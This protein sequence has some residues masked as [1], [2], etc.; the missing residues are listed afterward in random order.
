MKKVIVLFLLLESSLLSAQTIEGLYIETERLHLYPSSN[1]ILDIPS[2]DITGH[3]NL[4]IALS[5]IY[6]NS[7]F[8][9]TYE[10]NEYNIVKHSISPSL[11]FTIG[12]LE[13]VEIGV[14]IGPQIIKQ[15]TNIDTETKRLNITP[16][17]DLI[18]YLKL[19]SFELIKNFYLTT[20]VQFTIPIAKLIGKEFSGFTS[21]SVYP[22][23][24]STYKFK[25]IWLSLSLGYRLLPE[26]VIYK[27]DSY[28][29]G[30]STS[31]F[32][33]TSLPET[34][35]YQEQLL[36]SIDD[37]LIILSLIHI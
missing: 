5:T 4:W 22:Q 1:S 19:R 33:K 2:P 20:S 26:F 32:L 36:L 16:L 13:V 25:K 15:L 21:W 18:L 11:L 35:I 7:S 34:D 8:N 14:E 12:L 23:L 27:K 17:K 9:I 29:S 28:I 10:N 31:S 30:Y 24:I 6:S 3:T 37:E